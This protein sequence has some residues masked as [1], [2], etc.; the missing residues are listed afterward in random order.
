[1]SVNHLT[2]HVMS[3]NVSTKVSALTLCALLI[4]GIIG[5]WADR[6]LNRVSEE[7]AAASRAS[8]VLRN[9][10][11]ADMMHDALRGDVLSALRAAEHK[12]PASLTNATVDLGE[13][14]A[15]FNAVLAKS[16]TLALT[17][18]ITAAL[19]SAEKPLADYIA[20]ARSIVD[21]SHQGYPA[22]EKLFPAFLTTFSELESRM[23]I[24]SDVIEKF[25]REVTARGQQVRASFRQHL[26][27][28][29]AGC[30]LVLI[31]GTSLVVRSIPRPFAA[32][33]SHLADAATT[34]VASA[35]HIT[36]AAQSAAEDA[37]HQAASV[38]ET[39]ASLEEMAS[40]TRANAESAA[41]ARASAAQTR[42]SAEA[43]A[44]D[45]M[46]LS[47]AMEGIKSAS[48]NISRILKTIDEIAFQTNILALNAAVEAARAGEAG[49]GF[50]VVAEEVR[51]LARRSAQAARE[52]ADRI[53]DSIEASRRGVELNTKV[54]LALGQIVD[55][56]RGLD[57]LIQ[58]IATATTEQSEGLRQLTTAVNQ[59]DQITQRNAANSE[60]N[61]ASAAELRRQA[62]VLS[63]IVVDLESKLAGTSKAAFSKP[64]PA[65]GVGRGTPPGT[66]QARFAAAP[67]PRLR[68]SDAPPF[69][70]R[71]SSGVSSEV[72]HSG[73]MN[74]DQRSP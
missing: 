33:A 22:A 59:I 26:L 21:V 70:R 15:R 16:R 48:D 32:V 56:S 63:G 55:H 72:M 36:S 65:V 40:R 10:L 3:W 45:M 8:E 47:K 68:G 53:S 28:G 6:Q 37:N 44:A 25:G 18:E 27:Y 38:E 13:H 7:A 60:E 49:Q 74:R 35:D 73:S 58:G 50:A 24:L 66:L 57:T 14:A 61:A 69:Q 46:E 41:Q 51:T 31:L 30:I 17:P 1:M 5:F 34:T 64:T 19:Q 43:G 4:I 20:S 2:H 67:G 52:T 54:G 23:E 71:R 42:A 11:E 12:D 39:S 29:V 9:H 62:T